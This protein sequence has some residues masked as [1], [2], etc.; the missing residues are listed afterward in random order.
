MENMT[1]KFVR[2]EWVKLNAND[3]APK[4]VSIMNYNTGNQEAHIYLLDLFQSFEDRLTLLQTDNATTNA[5]TCMLSAH[6]NDVKDKLAKFKDDTCEN[7][8]KNFTKYSTLGET[9]S[10]L[11]NKLMDF[12]IELESQRGKGN[13]YERVESLEKNYAAFDR[14]TSPIKPGSFAAQLQ[15]IS[16]DLCKKLTPVEILPFIMP[17]EHK[18]MDLQQQIDKLNRFND[19]RIPLDERLTALETEQ[20]VIREFLQEDIATR[21]GNAEKIKK[22]YMDA[23]DCLI[24]NLKKDDEDDEQSN[25]MGGE[26]S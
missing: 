10:S 21:S 15:D 1:K 12:E 7:A 22:T 17:L 2:S 4:T 13:L 3:P 23:Y 9:T 8:A 18:I 20:K 14:L 5:N 19:S 11:E 26:R 24:A 16:V 6:L 25:T